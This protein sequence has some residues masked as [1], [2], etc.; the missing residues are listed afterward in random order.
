MN[1]NH[2]EASEKLAKV[3]RLKIYCCY[4]EKE[5][6][7]RLTD[8]GEIY[9]HRED[10]ADLPFWKCNCGNFV[11]CHHKTKNRTKPLGCIPN[12]EIKKA[13]MKIHDLL[14]PLWQ[15]GAFGRN[16]LYDQLSKVLGRKYHTAEL[17]SLEECAA[18]AKALIK[19]RSE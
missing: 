19:L 9:P 13:R 15:S 7:T 2:K 12:A 6:E 16:E 8:G 4:C 17:R 10:L 18:I 14:D 1:I 11:A 5:V 3:W